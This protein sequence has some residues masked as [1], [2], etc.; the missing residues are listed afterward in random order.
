MAT[1]SGEEVKA[2]YDDQQVPK[3]LRRQAYALARKISDSDRRDQAYVFIRSRHRTQSEIQ[4]FID[5][6]AD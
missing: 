2:R 6:L 4:A 3:A 1:L 5:R